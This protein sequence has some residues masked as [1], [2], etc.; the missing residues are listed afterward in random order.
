MFVEFGPLCLLIQYATKV[1][2]RDIAGVLKNLTYRGLT[3]LTVNM[4]GV[5]YSNWFS[6]QNTHNC[7]SAWDTILIR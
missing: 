7:F 4:K 2:T 5:K 3:V 1:V 6:E